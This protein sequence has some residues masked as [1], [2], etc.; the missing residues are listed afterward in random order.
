[1]KELIIYTLAIL[2]LFGLYMMRREDLR[3]DSLCEMYRVN[4][5]WDYDCTTN[6]EHLNIK[7]DF[8]NGKVVIKQ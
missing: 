2:G 4:I 3:K 7:Y 5:N 6:T 8:K 1:M